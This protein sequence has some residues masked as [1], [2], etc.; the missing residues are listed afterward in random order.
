LA[1]VAAWCPAILGY[2]FKPDCG[3]LEAWARE[4][5]LGWEKLRRARIRT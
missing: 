1:G 4:G 5:I 2:G 3:V